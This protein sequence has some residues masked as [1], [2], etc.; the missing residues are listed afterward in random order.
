M[1]VDMPDR[2]LSLLVRL[3]MQNAGQLAAGRRS[4]F[5]ELTD[6]ELRLIEEA[7]QRAKEEEAAAHPR[8]TQ[9]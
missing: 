4:S 8:R 7:V 2:R 6:E 9:G 1:I 3:C 5:S